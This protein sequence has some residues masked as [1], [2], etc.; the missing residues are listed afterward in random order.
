[1]TATPPL[2]MLAQGSKPRPR[3]APIFRPLEITLHMTV[4]KLLR[5]HARP[6]W[7]W[8][9]CPTVRAETYAWPRS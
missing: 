5:E 2:L 6:E 7:V 4:A 3:K 9:H 8:F 1:M